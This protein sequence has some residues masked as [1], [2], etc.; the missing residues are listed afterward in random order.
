[1]VRTLIVEGAIDPEA[2]ASRYVPEL[3]GTGLG[4]AKIREL[5]DMTASVQFFGQPRQPGEVDARYLQ[6]LGLLARPDG[7]EGPDGVYELLRHSKLHHEHGVQFR[8]ENGSTDTLGW[9]LRRVTRRSLQQL[10]AERLWSHLGME[11]DGTMMLDAR[12]TEWAAGGLV[13]N[14]R[15]FA[16]LG[17]LVRLEGRHGG[18]QVLPAA[19]F[20]ELRKGG[21]RQAFAAG[22]SILPGGSYHDQWWFYHDRHDSF[23]ARGQ[24]G[25]RLWIAPAAETVIVQFS[26]DPD[27]T[28]LQE[29]LRLAAW[30][31]IADTLARRAR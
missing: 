17:E 12:K 16:R 10:F 22:T 3:S 7:S 26:T 19:V 14:A 20:H 29:P 21:D 27:P 23:A 15:D 11:Q 1:M 25:Q 4:S 13:L 8:Y 5:L 24:F 30:Q 18:K 6:A 31:A 28:N 9:V 2:A